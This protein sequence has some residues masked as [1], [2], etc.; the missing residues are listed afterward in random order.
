[1]VK[2]SEKNATPATPVIPVA[3]T[4]AVATAAKT[5]TLAGQKIIPTSGVFL[6]TNADSS[7]KYIGT[8]TRIEICMKDYLKWLSDS[9]HGNLK[10]QAAYEANNK[11]LN[12]TIL[13]VCA[14]EDFAATKAKFCKEYGVD[15]AIPFSKEVVKAADIQA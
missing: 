11:M 8:S 3:A 14:K 1:M 13:E 15:M 7:Y 2:L 10:M 4:P 12:W 9:K 5:V 6:I